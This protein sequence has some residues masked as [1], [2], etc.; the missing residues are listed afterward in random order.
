MEY[1]TVRK[2]IVQYALHSSSSSL[3]HPFELNFFCCFARNVVHTL[4]CMPN[5]NKEV[6]T[7]VA[8]HRGKSLMCTHLN[9][10][11]L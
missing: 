4:V 10:R 5:N 1:C 6:G 7:V 8:A 11:Y 3:Y 9:I 2:I